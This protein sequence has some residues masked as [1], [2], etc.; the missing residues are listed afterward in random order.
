MY[1]EV[2]GNDEF[3]TDM[4][5]KIAHSETSPGVQLRMQEVVFPKDEPRTSFSH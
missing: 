4:R 1:K 5:R 2:N 3:G